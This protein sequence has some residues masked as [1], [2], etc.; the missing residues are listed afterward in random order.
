MSARPKYMAVQAAALF[1]GAALI[2]IGVAGFVPGITTNH[3]R[4]EWV[5]PHSQAELFG[6]FVVSGV[7]NAVNIVV[8]IVGLVMARSYAAARAYFLGGG[9]AYLG[10]WAYGLAADRGHDWLL[11]MLGVVM[12]LLGLTLAGQRDP[13]KRRP[14]LRATRRT[15]GGEAI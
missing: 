4:L 6:L 7:H 12:V 15:R 1:V 5:S 3:D 2:A 10:L 13:T 11:F 9:L 8:G 14:R